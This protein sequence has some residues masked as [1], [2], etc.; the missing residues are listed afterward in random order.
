M[1]CDP[2]IFAVQRLAD[3]TWLVRTQMGDPILP[4]VD[5]V[6]VLDEQTGSSALPQ[7]AKLDSRVDTGGRA[8]C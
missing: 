7:P 3:G 8:P 2:P 6:A 4:A 5:I 1:E